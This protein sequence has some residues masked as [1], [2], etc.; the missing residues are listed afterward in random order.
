MQLRRLPPHQLRLQRQLDYPRRLLANL[1]PDTD[2]DG[3]SERVGERGGDPLRDRV[4]QRLALP[5]LRS[6][7]CGLGC[8]TWRL[9]GLGADWLL[10]R[11]VWPPP[12]R[13]RRPALTDL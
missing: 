10:V 3:D 12:A 2:A 5:S 8:G 6:R 11:R 9:H 13:R 1:Q 7:V 4:S